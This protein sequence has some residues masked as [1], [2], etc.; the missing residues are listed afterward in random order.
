LKPEATR[1]FA[2]YT[3]K[4]IGDSFAITVDGVVVSA[5]V[6]QSEIKNGD[7]QITQGPEASDAEDAATIVAYLNYGAQPFPIQ[8]IESQPVSSSSSTP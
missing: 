2:D 1:L 5:P 3:A 8:E 7:V 4:N 6:I